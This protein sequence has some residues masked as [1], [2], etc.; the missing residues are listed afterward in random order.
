[1]SKTSVLL[2]LSFSVQRQSSQKE[3]NTQTAEKPTEAAS[4]C[5]GKITD[6]VES[7]MNVI[8]LI[9]VSGEPYLN[10]F[11][12]RE[13]QRYFPVSLSYVHFAFFQCNYHQGFFVVAIKGEALQ[14][15]RTNELGEP[16]SQWQGARVMLLVLCIVLLCRGKDETRWVAKF[17]FEP[18]QISELLGFC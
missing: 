9:F 7:S 6:L 16:Q 17:R 3:N 5:E 18:T 1:M 14:E 10:E 15:R 12:T 13:Q 2:G 4:E 8:V 11:L